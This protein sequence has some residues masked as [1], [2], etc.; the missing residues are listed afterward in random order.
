MSGSLHI[1]R[2]IIMVQTNSFLSVCQE[3]KLNFSKVEMFILELQYVNVAVGDF[4]LDYLAL[5]A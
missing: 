3:F 5:L 2:I 1:Y 4:F